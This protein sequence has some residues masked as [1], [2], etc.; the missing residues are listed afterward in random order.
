MNINEYVFCIQIIPI[1]KFYIYA[2]IIQYF[3]AH[4]VYILYIYNRPI[5]LS[6]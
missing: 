6:L 1:P 2:C 4:L 3:Y 5:E